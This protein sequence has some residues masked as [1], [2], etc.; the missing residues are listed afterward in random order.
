MIDFQIVNA[1]VTSDLAA[2][3]LISYLNTDQWSFFKKEMSE[4]AAK[5]AENPRAGARIEKRAFEIRNE[6]V[7]KLPVGVRIEKRAFEI[8][9]ERAENPPV[10]VRIEKRACEI[11]TEAERVENPPLQVRTT[12]W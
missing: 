9:R 10:V 1:P 7:E 6:R 12:F 2:F 8:R 4:K 11:R 3:S 5:S